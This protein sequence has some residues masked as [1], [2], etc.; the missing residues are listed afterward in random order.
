MG[1]TISLL[2]FVGEPEEKK[3]EKPDPDKDDI[4]DKEKELPHDN[5]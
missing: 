4:K 3:T 5:S 1:K 2:G